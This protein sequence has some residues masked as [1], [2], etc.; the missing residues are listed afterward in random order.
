MNII[1][2]SQSPRR[3]E[4]MRHLTADFLVIPSDFA[5]RD[6]EFTGDP[7]AYCEELALQ[8]ALVVAAD[9]PEDLILG[10][11]TIVFLDGELLNKPQDRADARR[12]MALMQGRSHDVLTAYTILIPGLD[13]RI[14]DHVA[15]QVT[16]APMT[17]DQIEDYLDQSDFMGKAGA[18][19]IQGAAARYVES[20]H[21]DFYTV[22]GLPVARLYREFKSLGII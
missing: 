7:A 11:D 13:V 8:K 4:L 6:V 5:E 21:G 10:C 18:Y 9:Y 16:F 14:T 1:L 2:A 15:T 19:A 22:V 20:I 12:M 17:G 3:L